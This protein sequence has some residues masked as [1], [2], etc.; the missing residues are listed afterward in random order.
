MCLANPGEE[1]T[2][3]PHADLCS[4]VMGGFLQALTREEWSWPRSRDLQARSRKWRGK[5]GIT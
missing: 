2:R 4:V 5:S 1:A 3:L